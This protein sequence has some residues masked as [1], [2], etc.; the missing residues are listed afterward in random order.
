MRGE[1]TL[2]RE[3]YSMRRRKWAQEANAVLRS[4]RPWPCSWRVGETVF[5]GLSTKSFMVAQ[6]EL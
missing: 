2:L 5:P 1:V 3:E 6:L 4:G